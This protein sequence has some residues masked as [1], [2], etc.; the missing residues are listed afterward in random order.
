MV[1]PSQTIL[2]LI[3]SVVLVIGYAPA[4]VTA[5]LEIEE[6]VPKKII[7]DVNGNVVNSMHDEDGGD[8]ALQVVPS[9]SNYQYT[10]NIRSD[11]RLDYVVNNDRLRVS[12]T[13]DGEAWIGLGTNPKRRGK[14]IGAE[15]W[16]ALP[17]IATKPSIYDLKGYRISAVKFAPNQTLENGLVVQAN[18]T[19]VMKFDKL[20]NDADGNV[21]IDGN[22]NL[23]FIWAIGRSNTFGKH[24][25]KGAFSIDLEPCTTPSLVPEVVEPKVVCGLF[26][27]SLFCP[28]SGCGLFGR[29]IGLC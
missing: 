16:V 6:I 9:C 21:D 13:Y 27:L 4:N 26:S 14:M 19:T 28:L 11:L 18:G 1:F 3:V 2:L 29:L 25:Q 5:H 24:R 10:A 22:D 20:L 17:K 15:A 12:L 23:V 7:Y 8:R